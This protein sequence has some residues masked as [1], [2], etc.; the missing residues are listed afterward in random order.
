MELLIIEIEQ[1]LIE[2]DKFSVIFVDSKG[3]FDQRAGAV[4]NRMVNRVAA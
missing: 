2:L 1:A 4:G 3:E